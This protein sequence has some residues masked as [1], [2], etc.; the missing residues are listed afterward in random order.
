MAAHASTEM[1]VL[2]DIDGVM[3]PFG[4][5]EEGPCTFCGET[6]NDGA[7]FVKL[8]PSAK[9]HCATA[10]CLRCARAKELAIDDT[11]LEHF[12][13][14]CLAALAK[15]IRVTGATICLSSTWRFSDSAREAIIEEFQN[16]GGD[17]LPQYDHFEHTTSLTTSTVRQWE[18]AEWVQQN[19]GTCRRWVAL[20]DDESITLDPKYQEFCRGHVVQTNSRVGLTD[21]DA[22][23]AIALL[24][25]DAPPPI[26][27]KRKGGG[28]SE[29]KKEKKRKK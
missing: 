3:L 20:D 19:R 27:M 1:F 18:V 17:T 23:R 4:C 21:A 5:D 8:Q 6:L 7:V 28:T 13:P 9:A 15:I 29:G 24:Q 14:A 2:L 25:Q 22:D 12:P 10:C 26:D 11:P 16:F